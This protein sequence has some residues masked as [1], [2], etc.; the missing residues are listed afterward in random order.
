LYSQVFTRVSTKQGIAPD[1]HAAG[2]HE[3]D[4]KRA[5]DNAAR[6]FDLLLEATG[7]RLRHVGLD[8]ADMPG[9]DDGRIGV[10]GDTDVEQVTVQAVFARFENCFLRSAVTAILEI[11]LGIEHARELVVGDLRSDEHAFRHRG[12]VDGDDLAVVAFRHLDDVVLLDLVEDLDQRDELEA[13]AEDL[14][15]RSLLAIERDDVARGQ[16]VEAV[17]ALQVPDLVGVDEDERGGG[18]EACAEDH[19][20]KATG[21]GAEQAGKQLVDADGPARP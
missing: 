4:G 20:Q 21:K 3:R 5:F 7:A 9:G 17:D 16:L 12:T 8:D 1:A 19:Q 13:G 10:L 6:G 11:G 15:L 2:R 18:E 14:G